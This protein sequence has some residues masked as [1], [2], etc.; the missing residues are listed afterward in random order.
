MLSSGYLCYLNNCIGIVTAMDEFDVAP[1]E[2]FNP[3]TALERMLRLLLVIF[4][5]VQEHRRNLVLSDGPDVLDY[6]LDEA[7][8]AAIRIARDDTR[9]LIRRLQTVDFSLEGRDDL[10]LN[11]EMLRFKMMTI[12]IALYDASTVHPFKGRAVRRG[13]PLYRRALIA[14]LHAMDGPLSALTDELKGPRGALEFKQGIEAMIMLNSGP[15]T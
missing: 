9:E 11:G 5:E 15:T 1:S 7:F 14:L 12:K 2:G 13:W 8:I 3:A 4:E 6:H 10:R